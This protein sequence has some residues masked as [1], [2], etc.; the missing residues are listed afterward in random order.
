MTEKRKQFE[1][2]GYVFWF[3]VASSGQWV[4]TREDERDLHY[5]HFT[6]TY[7][8]IP[9]IYIYDITLGKY[10]LIWGKP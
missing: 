9:K 5:F 1:L 6:R 8:R 3:S 4:T 2:F 10:K 7:Y